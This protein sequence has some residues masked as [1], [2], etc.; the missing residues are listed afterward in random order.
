MA[1]SDLEKLTP[2]KELTNEDRHTVFE[3]I[4]RR[5][6]KYRNTAELYALMEYNSSTVPE[7]QK[8]RRRDS[9]NGDLN[10]WAQG[11]LEHAWIICDQEAAGYGS[12]CP[13][14]DQYADTSTGHLS[15]LPPFE[16][17]SRLLNTILFIEISSHKQYS[18]RTRGFLSTFGSLDEEVI[19]ST[20]KNPDRTIQEAEKK[21]KDEHEKK[22]K[23]LRMVGVG[24]SAVAGG[25]LIGVTGG[26]G[27]PLVGAGVATVLG[28][29]GVGGTAAGLLAS[30]LASST[31]ICG[32]L[33]GVYG[34]RSTSAMVERH[35]RAIHDLALLPVH[36]QNH[37]N[38]EEKLSVRLCVSGWL[39]SPDD[40]A[41]PWEVFDDTSDTFALRWEVEAL[42][43]LSDALF[44]L[45]KSH[46][47]KYV[48]IEIL[49]RTVFASLMAAMSPIA[50]L[51][52]GQVIDNPWMNAKALAVK[53][54]L[55]LGDL[56]SKRVFGNRPV[57]LSGYSLGGLVI[58]E[59]LKHLA[60]LPPSETGDLVQDVFLFGTPTSTD[61][62]AWTSIRRVVAGRLVNGYSKDDYVLAVL[63]RV[64]DVSW[65]V[66]GLHPV[67]VMGV[68]NILCDH[69]DGHLKWKG[70]VGK[71]LQ[72]AQASGLVNE[73]VEE[74]LKNVE[75]L[76]LEEELEMYEELGEK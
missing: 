27:A 22:G 21:S 44:T 51:K 3:H 56:L 33:F 72:V 45:V 5:L 50:L 13:V 70:M 71:S 67:D 61:I 11:L 14:L 31:V 24:L 36:E 16:T 12:E 60:T 10:K 65:K 68:E 7:R 75:V 43:Q 46:A 35:T 58:H 64:S 57:T 6:A 34:A 19:V 59:A 30:G 2:A 69:V 28:W 47:M 8:T 66:A 40:I 18:S 26:L 54:G 49:K 25:V 55:V 39:A 38:D 76:D 17:L 4:F 15:R 52:I 73:R 48:K 42:E 53:A 29:L 1:T 41:K 63:C 23:T 20:L 74:Q 37:S 32:A 9:F 62:S